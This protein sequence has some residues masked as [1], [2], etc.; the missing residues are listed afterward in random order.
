MQRLQQLQR[1]HGM[2]GGMGLMANELGQ[3][4]L[5]RHA[6]GAMGMRSIVDMHGT[7]GYLHGLMAEFVAK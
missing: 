5:V 6:D 2:L 1:Q 7:L 4:G 3:Q